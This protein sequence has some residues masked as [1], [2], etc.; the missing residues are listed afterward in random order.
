MPIQKNKVELLEYAGSDISHARAAWASTNQEVT[1]DKIERIAKLLKFLADNEHG[2]PFE[3]SMLSFH[4]QGDIASH[5]H[6]LKH[7]TGV[8][9]NT[10]SARYK[11]M[12]DDLFYLPEEFAYQN[13]N[14]LPNLIEDLHTLYHQMLTFLVDN[15][16]ID[17]SRAKEVAR[18]ILPYSH[19]LRWVM[20]FNFRS[21]M[22]FQKLRN[23]EHAQVEIKEIAENMLDLVRYQTDSKFTHSLQAFDL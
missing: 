16:K 4:V 3:H 17:R 22:H 15:K 10:E 8:S 21:F 7:R 18:Y 23:S 9:I 2:T 13:N 11:E 19:Q 14:D 1:S 12:K 6:C 5:I 20:T